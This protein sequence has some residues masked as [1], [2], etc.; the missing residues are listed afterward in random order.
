[1]TKVNFTYFH[2]KLTLEA[3]NLQKLP[4]LQKHLLKKRWKINAFILYLFDFSASTLNNLNAET[5]S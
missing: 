3:R 2:R 5:L 4:I 1:M